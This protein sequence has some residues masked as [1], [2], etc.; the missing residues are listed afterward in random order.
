MTL[1]KTENTNHLES[2]LATVRAKMGAYLD[3]LG[4]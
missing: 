1:W 4:V 2:E 3:N